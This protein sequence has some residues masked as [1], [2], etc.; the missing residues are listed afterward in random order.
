MG[1][2]ARTGLEVDLQ[3]NVSLRDCVLETEILLE[4]HFKIKKVDFR[5]KFSHADVRCWGSKQLIVQ[6]LVN[7]CVN[8]VDAMDEMSENSERIIELSIAQQESDLAIMIADSG[9]GI[10]EDLLPEIFKPF[11]TTK[12]EG[13]GTGMGLARCMD[14]AE[15]LHTK[16]SVTNKTVGHGAVFCFTLHKSNPV[17]KKE[18]AA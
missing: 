6:I 7:L 12:G 2:F 17:Q 11:F 13:K 9:P 18:S 1:T 14:I 15:L 4:H 5:K 10:P 8:A 3:D 16:I